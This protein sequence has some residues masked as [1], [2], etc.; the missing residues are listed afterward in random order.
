MVA[1]VLAPAV[2][3]NASAISEWCADEVAAVAQQVAPFAGR[4]GGEAV[5]TIAVTDADRA[6]LAEE[7]GL[8]TAGLTIGAMATGGRMTIRV[9]I[10]CTQLISRTQQTALR[11]LMLHEIGHAL[12]FISKPMD[13]HTPAQ[14]EFEADCAANIMLRQIYGVQVALSY[15]AHGG[16]PPEMYQP[17]AAWLDTVASAPPPV[18]PKVRATGLLRVTPT[19]A[20]MTA[21]ATAPRP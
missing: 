11:F 19:T 7:V 21:T 14:H 10:D 9:V 18:R 4:L 16:C 2:T 15:G 20:T 1:L 5:L 13:P 17:T 12:Q 8:E 3:A 6:R